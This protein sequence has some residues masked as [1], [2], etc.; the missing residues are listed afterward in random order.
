MADSPRDFLAGISRLV[1]ILP[2]WLGDTV[3]ATPLLRALRRWADD[4]DARLLGYG[5]PGLDEI[6]DGCGLID[7]VITG[8]PAGLLGPVREARRLRALQADAVI[9]LPNSFRLALTAAMARTPR[10]LGYAR[11]GRSRLLTHRIPTGDS[12]ARRQPLSAVDYYLRLGAAIGLTPDEDGIRLSATPQQEAEAD[13]L[14]A[15]LRGRPFALLNPGA[16][17]LDKR[18]PAERFAALAYTLDDEFDLEIVVNGSPSEADLVRKVVASSTSRSLDLC[19]A[20]IRLGSLKAVCRRAALVVTNDTGTRHVAA[21]S[22]AGGVVTLYGPTDPAWAAINCSREIELTAPDGRI[23][24]IDVNTVVDAC[25]R[26]L[27]T[28]SANAHNP[29]ASQLT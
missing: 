4:V 16:N 12:A 13:R 1:V 9:L 29:K 26:L 6:L 15:P 3:M 5:R 20:G 22:G 24:S 11:D 19:A 28:N 18:W 7:E 17:R 25:Y 21:A 23:Q 8:R 27:R 2:S 14:L 10:R